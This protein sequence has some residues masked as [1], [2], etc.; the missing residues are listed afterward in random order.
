VVTDNGQLELSDGQPVEQDTGSGPRWAVSGRVEY[1]N[2]GQ[3]VR[4]YQPYFID[5]PVYRQ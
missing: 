4:A 1:D 5:Q 3:T 2:K